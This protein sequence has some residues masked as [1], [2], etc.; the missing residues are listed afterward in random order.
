MT[1]L[2]S[3]TLYRRAVGSGPRILKLRSPLAAH[4]LGERFKQRRA[5][6]LVVLLCNV[7]LGVLLALFLETRAKNVWLPD[8]VDYQ[9]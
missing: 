5:H 9:D 3:H 7:E 4:E 1:A 2:C 6:H 8:V